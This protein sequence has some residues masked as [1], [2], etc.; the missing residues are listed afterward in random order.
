MVTLRDGLI[1]GDK[2]MHANGKI[3]EPA[4]VHT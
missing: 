4:P 3:A 1:I 2:R